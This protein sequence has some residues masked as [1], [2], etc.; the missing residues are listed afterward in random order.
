MTFQGNW[1]GKAYEDR[2]TVLVFEPPRH[3]A[4]SHWSPLSGTPDTPEHRHRLDFTLE[5][6]GERTLVRL[7]QDHNPTEEAREHSEQMWTTLLDGLQQVVEDRGAHTEPRIID[8][9]A[10]AEAGSGARYE[11]TFDK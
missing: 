5:E 1:E 9:G 2:G 6:R 8:G 11:Q 10:D 4:Y 3:L 7:T